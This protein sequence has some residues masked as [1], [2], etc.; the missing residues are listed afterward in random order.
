MPPLHILFQDAF[1]VAINKP[2]GMI[3]HPGRDK[4]DPE[5]IAILRLRDLLGRRVYPVHRLDRPTSGVQLFALD[6]QTASLTQQAFARREVFKTYHAIIS[7]C[8]PPQWTCETPLKTNPEDEPLSA[9]TSFE[10]IAVT[11]PGDFPNHAE[12]ILSLLK[13][14]P[15]T[16]RFHQI[17]R[18]LLEAGFPIV[19]DF[20]YAGIERS[21]ELGEILGT[22][23]R[24]LLQSKN[25]K[26]T[27]PHTNEPLEIIAPTDPEFR[28]CFPDLS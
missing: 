15:L 8:T 4:E 26:L 27:H 24:M 12:L 23:T 28:K 16:G 10:R 18:H 22:G 13:A 1:L 9:E 6:K 3:V 20:R 19:G 11:S 7:G 25:L 5:D 14:S 21:F 17:R 2:A